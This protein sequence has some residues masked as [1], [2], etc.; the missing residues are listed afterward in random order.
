M[1]AHK[2]L[3][4]FALAQDFEHL[5]NL[6]LDFSK[7]EDDEIFACQVLRCFEGFKDEGKFV[8]L[9]N[10]ARHVS[11]PLGELSVA[12]Y[13]AMFEIYCPGVKSQPSYA[14]ICEKLTTLSRSSDNLEHRFALNVVEGI[15]KG[16]EGFL[17]K[18][19]NALL[20]STNNDPELKTQRRSLI[21]DLVVNL[22]QSSEAR[23]GFLQR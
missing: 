20:L 2:Q 5:L 14:K 8:D 3:K 4:L 6:W 22:C 17:V 10:H 15:K 11:E 12:L 1:F 13:Q 19:V 16:H 23:K 7:I 21:N 9:Y 18:V